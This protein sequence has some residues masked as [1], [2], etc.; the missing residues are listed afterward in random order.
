VQQ[1]KLTVN[2]PQLKNI[3]NKKKIKNRKKELEIG[4]EQNTKIPEME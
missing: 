1:I 4:K 3:S 2:P